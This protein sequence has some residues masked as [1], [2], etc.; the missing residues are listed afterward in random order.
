[1][2]RDYGYATAARG[3]WHNTPAEETSPTG[4][5][6]NWPTGLG[7]LR[8]PCWRGVAVRAEPGSQY[9]RDEY[10]VFIIQRTKIRSSVAE[11][12]EFCGASLVDG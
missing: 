3:K 5:F 11:R 2:P 1:V 8:F 10:N 4:P 6:E 7:F 12:N 9:N